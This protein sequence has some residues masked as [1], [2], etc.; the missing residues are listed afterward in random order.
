LNTHRVSSMNENEAISDEKYEAGFGFLLF[1]ICTALLI[2]VLS[3][4]PAVWL[5]R[6]TSSERMKAGLET[7]YAPVVFLIEKTP[8]RQAGEWWVGKWVDNPVGK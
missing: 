5:H 7:I 4:G 3:I 1:W 8:L 6:K 2:Y